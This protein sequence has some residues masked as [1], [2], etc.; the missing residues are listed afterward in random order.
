VVEN[1]TYLTFSVAGDLTDETHQCLMADVHGAID[2]RTQG[3]VNQSTAN[4][5]RRYKADA[6]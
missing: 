1:N 2:Q 5:Q 3:I 6:K 4:V